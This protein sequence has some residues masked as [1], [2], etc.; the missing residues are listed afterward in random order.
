MGHTMALEFD[1]TFHALTGNAPFPWQARLYTEYFAKGD[2]PPACCLPTGLGKTSVIAIWLIALANGATVPRRLIYVVN[3]RT[4]VDQTTEEVER[5][6]KVIDERLEILEAIHQVIFRSPKLPLRHHSVALSTLRGQFADNGDWCEDPSRPAVICGTVDMIGSRLLFSGYGIGMGKR[7][8]HAGFLGQDALLIH[9]E[10][11]LEPAFQALLMSIEK[12]QKR[13]NEFGKFLVMELTATSQTASPFVLD[14]DDY[15][16]STVDER[17]NSKKS[18]H[19]HT[20]ADFKKPAKE[21]WEKALTFKDSGKAILVF[22]SSVETV[23]DIAGKLPKEQV[24]TLTG[25][26][27]GKERDELVTDKTFARFLPKASDESTPGTVY[28]VCTSAGEVGVN[29]S[30]DHLVCDLTPFD[31]MAQRLGRVN[32]FGKFNECEVHV[33]VP[34]DSAWDDKHPLTEPRKKTLAL[35][36]KLNGQAS[37]KALIDL[38][39]DERTAAFTPLPT[40]LPATDI[41]FDAWALT[42]IKGKLPGRPPVE[43]YLHGVAEYE[44]PQT[45]VA[46]RHEV[47]WLSIYDISAKERTA[48]LV[49]M[50]LLTKERLTDRS[51]RVFKELQKLAERH[52]THHAWIVSDENEVTVQPLSYFADKDTKKDIER[53]TLLLDPASGGLNS[54]GMLDATSLTANDVSENADRCRRWND[55]SLPPD[56]HEV[57]DITLPVVDEE[58]PPRILIYF[59]RKNTG[60]LTANDPVAW[61]VHKH[62]VVRETESIIS[63][64]PLTDSLKRCLKLAAEFHDHGKKRA[65]FQT[66]LGNR[67]FNTGVWWAKSGKKSGPRLDVKYRHEFCSLHEVQEAEPFKHLDADEQML[68]LHLIAAHHG[69]ARPHFPADEVFDPERTPADDQKLAVTVPQR[70]GRLQRKYGRWGLAYLESLL[71]AADWAASDAPSEFITKEAN[72]E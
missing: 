5:Y 11:H 72:H 42:T 68:V 2:I 34:P 53:M 23:L 1:S 47:G 30:A 46:W 7:P 20:L 58:K 35:L 37:P 45:T 28:L 49:A 70:F 55:K 41:L 21:L 29:I 17:M 39:Q 57:E 44:P 66:M 13:C 69:R 71:R 4:V 25:T 22:A 40:I 52:P 12:E 65:N 62:D 9:D 19:I 16:D 27:R 18:F 50:P 67:K 8:L 6:K 31:S 32:R 61:E 14:D 60:E 3:R 24:K 36:H 51:D 10:A 33:F 15:A 56:L 63:R 64:L 26:M 48:A 38:P 59:A 43:P 54:T